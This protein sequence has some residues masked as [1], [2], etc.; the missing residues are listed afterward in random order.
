VRVSRPT[1]KT[2]ARASLRKC[3][4]PPSSTRF[5]GFSF[6]MFS[7]LFP[8]LFLL[9]LGLQDWND[10]RLVEQPQILKRYV[11][12]LV[13]S[14]PLY[15]LSFLLSILT[16]SLFSFFNTNSNSIG[17]DDMGNSVITV[18]DDA[19]ALGNGLL[20]NVT[21]ISSPYLP[22]LPRPLLYMRPFIL[23]LILYYFLF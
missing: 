12:I 15:S 19:V 21:C 7:T 18:G 9:I 3:G 13:L 6:C 14:S 22:S 16:P 8:S 5:A 20:S 11:L 23:I 10:F 4:A 17:V 1:T 2:K